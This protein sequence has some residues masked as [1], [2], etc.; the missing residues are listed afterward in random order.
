MASPKHF[1]MSESNPPQ[2]PD[3]HLQDYNEAKSV[4]RPK[5]NVK[6]IHNDTLSMLL[7]FLCTS[8]NVTRTI[9]FSPYIFTHREANLLVNLCAGTSM[10]DD[11]CLSALRLS[12]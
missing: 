4:V 3:H 9:H 1:K 5:S 7:P 2:N 10:R 12:P 8:E 11:T 6:G